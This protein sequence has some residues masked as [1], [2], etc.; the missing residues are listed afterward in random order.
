M[1]IKKQIAPDKKN[2]KNQIAPHKKKDKK[3]GKKRVWSIQTMVSKTKL[4]HHTIT[5]S[6]QSLWY[7]GLYSNIFALIWKNKKKYE[8]KGDRSIGP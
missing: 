4:P 1:A 8:V 6:N 5:P 3:I 7:S 2:D